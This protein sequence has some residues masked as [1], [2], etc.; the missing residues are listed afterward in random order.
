MVS[1]NWPKALSQEAVNVAKWMPSI[2]TCIWTDVWPWVT[3]VYIVPQRPTFLRRGLN[4]Y[5]EYDMREAWTPW[6][7]NVYTSPSLLTY[8]PD[9]APNRS[10]FVV[11]PI[12]CVC[13]CVAATLSSCFIL[14]RWQRDFETKVSH[15]ICI[16]ITHWVHLS[17]LLRPFWAV[18]STLAT[19]LTLRTF[20]WHFSMSVDS[21]G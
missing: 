19:N 6:G 3:N 16:G 11:A 8:S 15:F 17:R 1:T 5:L 18:Y 13:V 21:G 2:V 9:L 12:K 20:R 7:S 14:C 10:I 4:I